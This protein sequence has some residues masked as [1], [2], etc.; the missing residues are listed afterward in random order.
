MKRSAS[1]ALLPLFA[2][3]AA[4]HMV[5]MLFAFKDAPI[6]DHAGMLIWWAFLLIDYV[7]MRLFL[8]RT[9]ELRSIVLLSGAVGAGQLLVTMW[10]APIYPSLL[11]WAVAVCMWAALYYRCGVALLEGVKPEAVMTNF[12]VLSLSLFAAAV[13]VTGNAMDEG[14]LLHLAV[15]LLCSLGALM[16]VRTMHTRV[17]PEGERPLVRLL[18]PL[19]LLGIGG[20]APILVLL[21]SGHAAELLTRFTAWLRGMGKLLVDAVGTFFLWLFSLFPEVDGDVSGDALAGDALP[22]GAMEGVTTSNAALLYVL[23]GL[24]A[25]ALVYVLVRV[26]RKVRVQG[27]RQVRRASKP[28]VVK[29]RSLWSVVRQFLRR[30]A[31]RGRFEL[32]YLRGYNTAAG[33]LVWLERLMGRK[34]MGRKRGET[35]AEFLTRV[36]VL[37][38]SCADAL[39]ELS[40]CLDRRFFGGGGELSADTV[41]KTRK[42]VRRAMKE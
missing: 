38:P 40:V 27:Q 29:G 7:V 10:L 12:E 30:L 24:F 35:V 5:L 15:G 18:P 17:G 3:A 16:G 20:C 11:W 28:V 2:Y 9:R 31:Q 39:R 4:M 19:L 32:R 42:A 25:F 36:A 13:I 41:R 1:A 23:V 8:R 22:S 33:L 26:W 21:I 6:A 34:R 14:V 37:L